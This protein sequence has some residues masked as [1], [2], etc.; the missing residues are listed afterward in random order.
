MVFCARFWSAEYVITK[1]E[2]WS[3]PQVELQ[4]EWSCAIGCHSPGIRSWP[5]LA[6]YAGV[7][8]LMLNF[9]R[10]L[11]HFSETTGTDTSNSFA[12]NQSVGRMLE[13]S[14]D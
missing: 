9:L 6:P 10:Q 11:G 4:V 2:G 13:I 8:H 14:R 12:V 1:T 7:G 3:V 5:T